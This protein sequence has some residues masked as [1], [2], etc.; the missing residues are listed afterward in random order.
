[1]VKNPL[2][3]EGDAR[4]VGLIP[5]LGRSPGEGNGNPFQYSCPGSPMERGALVG[6]S[7]WGC[8]RV[9]HDLATRQQKFPLGLGARHDLVSCFGQYIVPGNDMGHFCVE[10][11][12]YWC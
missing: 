4:D 11:S 5:G 9:G 1:M 2:V 12:S 10:A 3:N 7:P 6:Y 8:K